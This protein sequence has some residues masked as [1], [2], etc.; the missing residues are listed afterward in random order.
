[1][2]LPSPLPAPARIQPSRRPRMLSLALLLAGLLWSTG[3][4][5]LF[6]S[7]TT[8][9]GAAPT[10]VAALPTPMPLVS[11]VQSDKPTP[12]PLSL[13]SS[14]STPEAAPTAVKSPAATDAPPATPDP[15]AARVWDL[16]YVQDGTLYRGDYWGNDARPVI[17][18][19]LASTLVLHEQ[20]LA[21]DDLSTLVI[22]D[23][24]TGDVRRIE[25]L[26]EDP[27]INLHFLWASD[28]QALAYSL[29]R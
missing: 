28:G 12:L 20:L 10:S 2:T 15:S 3:C 16:V 11:P 23:L 24:A 5:V 21:Y 22:A 29:N 4:N 7:P 9:P 13:P 27:T 18:V 19:G 25:T 14:G 26:P 6:E 17:D 8:A 1:M